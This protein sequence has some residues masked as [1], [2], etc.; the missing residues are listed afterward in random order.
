MGS[1]CQQTT[2][3]GEAS[4]ALA[5]DSAHSGPSSTAEAHLHRPRSQA[6]QALRHV[7]LL[8]PAASGPKPVPPSPGAHRY[9][10]HVPLQQR[11]SMRPTEAAHLV[12]PGHQSKA[13][14]A[15]Q[16]RRWHRTKICSATVL[17][18]LR[19]LQGNRDHSDRP[20]K[21]GDRLNSGVTSAGCGGQEL[22]CRTGH[23]L[24]HAPQIHGYIYIFFWA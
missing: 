5:G 15:S 8:S 4:S 11:C 20:G 23:H 19:C 9:R 18:S 14:A 17:L 13:Q 12:S 22:C 3:P 24:R 21:A 10:G 1:R 16:Q 2:K 7:P 6:A